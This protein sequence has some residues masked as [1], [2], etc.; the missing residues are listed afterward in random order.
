MNTL[1]TAAR[2]IA[3]TV[4]RFV[5]IVH[6]VPCMASSLRPSRH[7]SASSR[8]LSKVSKSSASAVGHKRH[9]IGGGHIHLVLVQRAA[10]PAEI[11]GQMRGRT[12][13]DIDFSCG[14]QPRS[15]SGIRSITFRVT[16]PSCFISSISGSTRFMA[17]LLSIET[18]GGLTDEGS[19]WA[20][21]K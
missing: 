8:F 16:A 12:P 5:F 11:I 3:K 2:G 15:V 10:H 7:L 14:F 6:A 13:I 20:S 19:S 21:V 4:S 17:V 1:M 18:L 9:I